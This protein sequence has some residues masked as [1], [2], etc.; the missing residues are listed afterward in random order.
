MISER[1]DNAIH[2][3]TINGRIDSTTAKAL[4]DILLSRVASFPD[5]VVDLDQVP[6][7]SSAGLRVLLRA[8]RAA[9]E[10]SHHLVLSGLSQSV[11]EVFDIT[12]FMAL[13]R[14]QPDLAAALATLR[15]G[16]AKEA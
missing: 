12:G 14:I 8:A 5:V 6:Y 11:S 7:V 3:L 1:E 9:A 10:K 4:D 2:V 15:E 13:F 16:R